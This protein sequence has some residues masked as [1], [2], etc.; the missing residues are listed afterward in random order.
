MVEIYILL[1]AAIDAINATKPH[2][3]DKLMLTDAIK[4]VTHADVRP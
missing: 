1:S 4:A 2:F 3:S